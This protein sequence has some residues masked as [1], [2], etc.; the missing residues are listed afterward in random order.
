MTNTSLPTTTTTVLYDGSC[1]L[2]SREINH[3]RRLKGAEKI[4]WIDASQDE[5]LLSEFGVSQAEALAYFHVFDA[6]GQLH[7][8]A[9]GFAQVWAQLPAYRWLY[10]S[11]TR[12][13]L[14]PLSEWVYARFAKWRFRNTCQANSCRKH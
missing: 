9:Y 12:L 13:H 1:P 4:R 10:L 3:Y 14:L 8:G 11:L 6:D 5:T 7:K 2:C